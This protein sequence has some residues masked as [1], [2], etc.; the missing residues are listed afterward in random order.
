MPVTDPALTDTATPEMLLARIEHV[1]KLAA[2]DGIDTIIIGPGSDLRYLIGTSVASHERLTCLV[3]GAEG[4]TLVLPAL[5]RPAWP[6]M[7]S[8]GLRIQCWSDGQD[9]YQTVAALA[10]GAIGVD[11]QMSAGHALNLQAACGPVRLAAPVLQA[12]RSVKDTHEIQALQ[13]AGRAIDRVQA[14]MAQ[15]LRPGRTERQVQADIAAALVEQGHARADFVIVGSGPNGAIPHHEASDRV[16][17]DGDA[18]VID[19]GGPTPAGYYSDC[20]RTYV[21]GTPSDTEFA[22]VH[23]IVRRAQQAA[24]DQVRPGVSGAQVDAAARQVITE[25]GYG[26]YYITRTG[27][28]IGLDVHEVPFMVAGNDQEVLPGQAFSIEPGIYLPG[29]FGVRIEDI[30]FVDDDGCAV[31]VNNCSKEPLL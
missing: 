5:E 18:V 29:R 4:A 13:A 31:R 16:I 28:G 30:V 26:D 12:A 7:S 27:H 24:V 19:I 3:V 20:T 14:Q 1:T 11:A 23:E 6:D 22:T 2:K 15:W 9:P 10:H 8:L 17:V 25:A 21:L